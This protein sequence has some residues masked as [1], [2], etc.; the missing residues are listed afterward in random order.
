MD[1][2]SPAPPLV[3]PAVVWLVVG[4]V[5]LILAVLLTVGVNSGRGH[6]SSVNEALIQMLSGACRQYRVESGAYPPQDGAWSTSLLVKA[7]TAPRG[8]RPPIVEFLPQQLSGTG[9]VIDSWG[10]P[11]R[12]RN[13]GIRNPSGVDIESPGKNGVF[14]DDDDLW[15]RLD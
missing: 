7:L 1:G 10:R 8:S 14:G 15:N 12:Y 5:I 9:Q 2:A 11:L 4:F 6:P 13:P 3:R